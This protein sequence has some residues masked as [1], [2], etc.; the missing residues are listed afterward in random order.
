M[1]LS[2]GALERC[3]NSRPWRAAIARIS[4]A[5]PP[6][7]KPVSIFAAQT[8]ATPASNTPAGVL[9][10]RSRPGSADVQSNPC[11]APRG[12]TSTSPGPS[13]YFASSSSNRNCPSHTMNVS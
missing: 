2:G 10:V 4:C 13:S 1:G 3:R 9:I 7:G 8:S 5:T 6:V 12:M 11:H